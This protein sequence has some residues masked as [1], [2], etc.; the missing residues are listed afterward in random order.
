MLKR[1]ADPDEQ[2]HSDAVSVF[3]NAKKRFK[4]KKQNIFKYS[5][6]LFPYRAIRRLIPWSTG[7]I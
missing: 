1:M 5:Y 6:E 2:C 7:A 4:K 3:T